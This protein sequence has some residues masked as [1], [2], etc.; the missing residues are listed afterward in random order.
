VA[1]YLGID[2][3]GTKTRCALGDETRIL[4]SSVAGGSNV[5]RAGEEQARESLHT[6]V[7]EV[8]ATAKISPDKIHAICIGAAGAGRPEVAAKVQSILAEVTR[9]SIEV[10]GDMIIALLKELST[11]ILTPNS[12]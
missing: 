5:I 4:A 12:T 10:V 1:F 3:G 7:L 8:C 11:R 2:G 6:S 9:A